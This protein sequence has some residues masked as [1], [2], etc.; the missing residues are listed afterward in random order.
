MKSNRKILVSFV[1][2]NDEGKHDEK[3]N[4]KLDGAI[5]T[6]LKAIKNIDEVFLLWTPPSKDN[7]FYKITNYLKGEIEKRKLCNK[8]N[9]FEFDIVNPTD[10]NE[11]YPK[12]LEFCKRNVTGEEVI[13]AI[14]SGTPAMQVCWILM[15]ESGDFNLKL[16]R[17]NEPKYSKSLITEIKLGTGLPKIVKRL[18]SENKDLKKLL[19][20]VNMNISKGELKIGNELIKL[21]P[22][23]FAYYRYFLERA[24]EEKKYERF[25]MFRTHLEFV[26]KII[27]YHNDSFPES[28]QGILHTIKLLK[29]EDGIHIG[30]F[31]PNLNRI[32][33][34][35]KSI[36]ISES[37][38]RYFIIESIGARQAL[39]YGISLSGEKINIF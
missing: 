21:S 10:H 2:T 29:N 14:A 4:C 23:Q 31:R 11:I 3:L 37:L 36:L 15:A 33:K 20:I 35:I 5:L 18:E 13:A 17:S 8:V 26:K 22:I 32:N 34:K 38:S 28:D 27:K 39:S 19:P 16:I 6:A 1:G 30:N 7:D 24:K 12:L 9:K 25:P